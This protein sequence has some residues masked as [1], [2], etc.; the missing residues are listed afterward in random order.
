[1]KKLFKILLLGMT[2]ILAMAAPAKAGCFPAYFLETSPADGGFFYNK[3]ISFTFIGNGGSQM[4]V[5]GQVKLYRKSDHMLMEAITITNYYPMGST[6]LSG[7]KFVFPVTSMLACNTAYY[8]VIDP[9][10]FQCLSY[11]FDV[12]RDSQ[13][14]AYEWNFTT[15]PTPIT[16]TAG[17]PAY[18]CGGATSTLKVNEANSYLWSN[19]DTTRTV[20][21]TNP[22]P[23]SVT[24][25]Y[26]NGCQATSSASIPALPPDPIPI[27][28]VT[29]D[30]LSQYNEVIWT[31]TIPSPIDSFI[32]YR[33]ISTNN[34]QRLG[35]VPC[36]GAL[37]TFTDTVRMKYFPNTGNPNAGTYRYKLRVVDTCGQYSTHSP[38]HNT[39]FISNS[40]GTFSWNQ[41]Y[42]IEGGAN[43]VN[44]YVLM[45][46]DSATGHWHAI[47][48]VSGTQY[49]VTDPAYDIYKDI[50]KWRVETLW[51][52]ICIPSSDSPENTISTSRS[53]TTSRYPVGITETNFY[54]LFTLS[55]N[56]TNGKFSLTANKNSAP[57]LIVKV[58]NCNGRLLVDQ[59]V[60]GNQHTFDL[61][62]S[63]AGVYLV[64]VQN[65]NGFYA[66]RIVLLSK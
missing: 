16:F 41:L 59:A 47:N 56:P 42:S 36:Q 32:V 65:D 63:S 61:T 46:D 35:A 30:S 17:P 62:G 4:V 1:M 66:A 19:G 54:D 37:S 26:I 40:N 2:F 50:A 64:Q 10:A 22:N 24:V 9:H 60:K 52:I 58:F 53:N 31:K 15:A 43:P 21:V 48:S 38:W 3:S 44:S 25:S 7:G 5:G 6:G 45:R 49:T 34:Y 27:C 11:V 23:Y 14:V 33:E 20:T 29:V 8:V 13:G 39:I 57:G 18:F 12:I 51:N 55:P 28:M